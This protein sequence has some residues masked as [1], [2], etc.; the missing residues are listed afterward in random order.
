MIVVEILPK[1]EGLFCPLFFIMVVLFVE[2]LK[3]EL[4]ELANEVASNLGY[5]IYD[6]GLGR[7][8]KKRLVK[9][10]IDKLDGYVSISDCESFSADFGRAL[11]SAD[12]VPFSYD[13]VVESPGLE[14]ALRDLKDYVRFTGE[15]AKVILKEPIE[16]VSVLIGK[17]ISCEN[18]VVTVESSENGK[19]IA[20]HFSNVKRA[21]LKL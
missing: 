8:G 20:F 17:I 2:D 11:D 5:S 4:F 21:N 9:I 1:G 18:D 14:R 15:K 10:T 16:G 6:L 13:L 12:L 3:K 7:R 19:E